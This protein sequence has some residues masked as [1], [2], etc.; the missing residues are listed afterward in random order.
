MELTKRE[1][2][3]ENQKMLEDF[4]KLR[5]AIKNLGCLCSK[6]ITSGGQNPACLFKFQLHKTELHQRFRIEYYRKTKFFTIGMLKDWHVK[7][8]YEDIVEPQQ[9]WLLIFNIVKAFSDCYK[10][11]GSEK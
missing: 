9:D 10:N 8:K 1:E 4:E 3:E 11:C 5:N 6:T 7:N 2:K